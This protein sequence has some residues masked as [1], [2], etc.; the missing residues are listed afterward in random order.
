M[1]SMT[2]N[3]AAKLFVGGLA[4]ETTDESLRNYFEQFAAVKQAKIMRSKKLKIPQGFGYVTVVNPSTAYSIMN[5]RHFL[6]G[7]LLDVKIAEQKVGAAKRIP[8]HTMSRCQG[9]PLL[10]D[11]ERTFQAAEK[12]VGHSIPT[13]DTINNGCRFGALTKYSGEHVMRP[14]VDKS[15]NHQFGVNR[16]KISKALGTKVYGQNNEK[17]LFHES[18]MAK[19]APHNE[20]FAASCQSKQNNKSSLLFAKG[21]KEASKL[22]DHADLNIRF[23]RSG[24]YHQE[25]VQ[26]W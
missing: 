8:A 24:E 2:A 22:L 11:L 16:S 26:Y 20:V 10:L 6:H 25:A 12:G 14:L 7:R 9:S 17:S 1:H 3:S 18:S 19:A 13:L 4:P 5:Q 15:L 23:N 21:I